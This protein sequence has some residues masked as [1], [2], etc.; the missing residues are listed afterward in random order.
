MLR[1]IVPLYRVDSSDS[2]NKQHSSIIPTA[3]LKIRSSIYSPLYHLS[4][5][6]VPLP[7]ATT[8]NW[9]NI[10][11]KNISEAYQLM[12]EEIIYDTSSPHRTRLLFYIVLFL[13]YIY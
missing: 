12:P 8:L 1:T 7:D 3:E 6:G 4:A 13:F 2:I 9:E 11:V 5:Y 10:S